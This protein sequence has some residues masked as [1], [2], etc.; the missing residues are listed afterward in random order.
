[1]TGTD[2]PTGYG[3]G[4]YDPTRDYDSPTTIRTRRNQAAVEMAQSS[5]IDSLDIPAFLRKQAD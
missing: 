5:G 1:M 4:G 3:N 2:G